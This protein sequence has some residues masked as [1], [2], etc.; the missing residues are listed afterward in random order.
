MFS[1]KNPHRNYKVISKKASI[2]KSYK[3][4][5]LI[6]MIICRWKL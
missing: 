3:N 4:V 1:W 6:N 2:A 5:I